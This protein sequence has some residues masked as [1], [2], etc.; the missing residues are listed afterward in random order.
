[1]P[2]ATKTHVDLMFRAF[3]DPVRLR[4]LAV[5]RDGELC[6]CDLVSILHVPQPTVSRHLAYLLRAGLVTVR[7][8][9]SWNFYQLARAR[10][11]FHRK[12]LE[13]LASCFRDV[14][15]MTQ[16]A[17]RARANRDRGGCC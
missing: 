6:V 17:T 10:S 1:M 12:L 9:R 2:S 11:A 15:E 8:E 13:C 14:P 7:E 5:I 16:D 4:I 3:S